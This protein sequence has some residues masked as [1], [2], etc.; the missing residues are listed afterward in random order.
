MN[1]NMEWSVD[2]YTQ[3]LE[4]RICAAL[5][6]HDEGQTDDFVE[7]MKY[8]TNSRGGHFNERHI[9]RT[10]PE[11]ASR[12]I[13]EITCSD[14][15]AV[16]SFYNDAYKYILE[17]LLQKEEDIAIWR[18]TD[19]DSFQHLK[20]FRSL[21]LDIDLPGKDPVGFGITTNGDVLE[22]KA[23]RVVLR[24]SFED[25]NPL[26]F[27]LGEGT[28]YPIFDQDK[29]ITDKIG[30]LLTK[31]LL[32]NPDIQAPALNKAAFYI[33]NVFKN[34]QIT[35]ERH[36]EESALYMDIGSEKYGK[37]RCSVYHKDDGRLKIH[38][39]SENGIRTLLECMS[40]DKDLMR[41]AKEI[42]DI[43]NLAVGGR[44]QEKDM[45]TP[46]KSAESI[47]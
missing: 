43:V 9:G 3:L 46:V 20:D 5:D 10:L 34:V 32:T 25:Y 1:I 41:D 24:R 22:T 28:A 21:V 30:N 35:L 33:G 15:A 16:S 17:G 26:G 23:F 6:L 27:T 42:E 39:N 7:E 29:Y 45:Q 31:D 47:R 8:L 12:L 13:S 37:V 36:E 44:I 38:Y 18:L 2:E 40:D 11:C 14:R 4:D 19:K